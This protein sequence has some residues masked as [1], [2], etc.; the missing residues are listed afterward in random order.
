MFFN[1]RGATIERYCPFGGVETLI[2]WFSQKGTFCDLST[3]NISMLAGVLVLTVLL[4]R[5]FCSHICPLGTLLEWIGTI[6]RRF[7]I[8]SRKI[9]EKLDKALRWLKYPLL[10]AILFFTVKAGELVFRTFDPYYLFFTAG[11]GHGIGKAGIWVL[12]G[13]F[14]VGI[15]APLS[16][17]KYLC[18]MAACLA[19]LCRLGMVRVIRN[20][21]L[22]TQCGS[23]DAACEW[24][25]MVSKT[26]SV[27]NSECS[28]CQDCVRACPTPGNLT[29]RIRRT[30]R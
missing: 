30:V 24:G 5:V 23:C 12:F 3:V 7:I 26:K 28:N 21:Q 19:P 25:I 20:D 29:L 4:K 18:P 15:L 17:C 8:G 11:T 14:L 1:V 22:C 16:F 2:P 10:V 9:P 6:G 27:T 13:V